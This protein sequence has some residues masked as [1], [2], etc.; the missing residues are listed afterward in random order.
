MEKIFSP[1]KTRIYQFIEYKGITKAEFCKKTGISY[2]NF[3]GNASKSEVGGSQIAKILETFEEINPDWLLLGR[4]EML[5]NYSFN[6][7]NGNGQIVGNNNKINADFRSYNSDSPDVLRAQIEVLEER[8]KEKDA[9]IK[10]K[11]A[12]IKALLEIL[13]GNG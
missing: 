5:R 13:K 7:N 6:I 9:Q 3:K 2:G 8:I 1:I 11:D 4:G 12:Q 10:E